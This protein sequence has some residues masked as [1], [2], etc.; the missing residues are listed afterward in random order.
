MSKDKTYEYREKLNKIKFENSAAIAEE[1]LIINNQKLLN[2]KVN[3]N[4]S[5]YD[6]KEE[7]EPNPIEINTETNENKENKK[8]DKEPIFL[9][10][11]EDTKTG[12]L[13]AY[14]IGFGQMGSK[15]H[16]VSHLNISRD[17]F[18]AKAVPTIMNGSSPTAIEDALAKDFPSQQTYASFS[19]YQQHLNAGNKEL[20]SL[21]I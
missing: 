16:D 12:K 1:T 4:R 8:D 10:T 18:M 15:V 7:V 19:E 3:F 5:Q 14:S 11:W 21:R 17:E 20:P 13:L 2:L 9:T 6:E